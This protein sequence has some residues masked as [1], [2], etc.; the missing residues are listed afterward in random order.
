MNG[1]SIRNQSSLKRLI[2]S[3]DT[4]VCVPTECV[5]TNRKIIK[6]LYYACDYVVT[7]LN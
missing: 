7:L 2:L 3:L 1:K 5:E 4:Y 6:G